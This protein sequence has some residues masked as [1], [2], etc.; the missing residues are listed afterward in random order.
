MGVRSCSSKEK[1][2]GT[3]HNENRMNV[4]RIYLATDNSLKKIYQEKSNR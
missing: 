1:R 3:K 4:L 2:G